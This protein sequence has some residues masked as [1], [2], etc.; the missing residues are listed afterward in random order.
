M[1]LSD[2]TKTL[3]EPGSVDKAVAGLLP[4]P[5]GEELQASPSGEQGNRRLRSPVSITAR[6]PV[7][8]AYGSFEV[9]NLNVKVREQ[10]Y[11]QPHAAHREHGLL[12]PALSCEQCDRRHC[13]GDL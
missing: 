10:S 2:V 4:A 7:L 9:N 6:E 3:L 8:T 5:A 1:S 11:N 13:D 12:Q